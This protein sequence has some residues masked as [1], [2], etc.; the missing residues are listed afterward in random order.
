MSDETR[1]VR[2]PPPLEGDATSGA[3]EG[4]GHPLKGP[5][6]PEQDPEVT[7]PSCGRFAGTYERCPYCGTG[8]Q[9][10]VSVRLLRRLSLIVAFVGVFLT[11]MAARQM[12]IPLVRIQELTPTH[13]FAILRVRG[14]VVSGPFWGERGDSFYCGVDDG[15]GRVNL[16]G[17]GGM[18]D[19]LKEL[20]LERGDVLEARGSIR[21]QQGKPPSMSLATARHVTLVKKKERPPPPPVVRVADITAQQVSRH[22]AVRIEGTLTRVDVGRVGTSAELDDGSGALTVWVFRSD[23]RALGAGYSLLTSGAQVAIEGSL[24]AYKGRRARAEVTQLKPF[25]REDSIQR[26]GGEG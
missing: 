18:V 6:F 1:P 2:D 7:C 23:I 5:G 19:D 24:D 11:W 14:E 22:Q 26:L 8:L 20:G 9:T 13:N 25:K 17:Y 3:G 12:E 10:R 21:I 16:R 15:S 4:A